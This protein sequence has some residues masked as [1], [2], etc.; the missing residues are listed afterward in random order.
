MYRA[1]RSANRQRE[2]RARVHE[3]RIGGGNIEVNAFQALSNV[4]I[5]K[6]RREGWGLLVAEAF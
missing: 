6:S 5:Q 4:V 2:G 3:P 1:I